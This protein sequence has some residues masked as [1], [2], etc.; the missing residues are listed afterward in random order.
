MAD[1]LGPGT[2]T[3]NQVW[4]EQ[5]KQLGILKVSY[6]LMGEYL[7]IPEGHVITDIICDRNSRESQTLTVVISGSEMVLTPEG[8]PL[9]YLTPT[10]LTKGYF[11]REKLRPKITSN[12]EEPK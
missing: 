9:T 12:D 3:Q 1:F 8:A 11:Q 4:S 6:E 5:M 2:K 10:H 7:E